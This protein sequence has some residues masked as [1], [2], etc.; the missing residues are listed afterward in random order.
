MLFPH[1]SLHSLAPHV[2]KST[3]FVHN[4]IL[5]F[6]KILMRSLKYVFLGYTQSQKSYVVTVLLSTNI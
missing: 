3:C 1:Q 2:F 5:G 6:D 4:Q